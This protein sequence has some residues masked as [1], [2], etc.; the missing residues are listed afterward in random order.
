MNIPG[1]IVTVI[2]DYNFIVNTDLGLMRFIRSQFQDPRA[3]NLDIVNKKDGELL[4]LLYS[5]IDKNPL[6]II[7]TEENMKD[8]DKLYLSFFDNYKNEIVKKSIIDNSTRRF[9]SM[10]LRVEESAG[11]KVSL[12]AN[13]EFE[14]E[15]LKKHFR[16]NAI[17]ENYNSDIKSSF[18][19]YYIRD[20]TFIEKYHLENVKDKKFY[21]NPLEYNLLYLLEHKDFYS[22]NIIS[23]MGTDYG[24]IYSKERKLDG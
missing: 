21:I 2:V 16:T 9:L 14:K 7:S 18:S 3:F 20:Y 13:D 22:N 1:Q 23:I 8:I 4:T 15:D 19:V 11:V 5:R 6:S 17:T 12:G 10:V 24:K